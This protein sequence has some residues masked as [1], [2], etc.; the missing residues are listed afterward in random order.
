MGYPRVNEV[1][2]KQGKYHTR[3][4]ISLAPK[5]LL[6]VVFLIFILYCKV[7]INNVLNTFKLLFARGA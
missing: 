5:V 4:A 1:V 2:C 6:K 3:C 7:L